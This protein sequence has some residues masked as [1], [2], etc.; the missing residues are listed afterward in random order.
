MVLVDIT[1]R[2]AD[3]SSLPID[4]AIGTYGSDASKTFRRVCRPWVEEK[5]SGEQLEQDARQA[6]HVCTCVVPHTSDHLPDEDGLFLLRYIPCNSK[7]CCSVL[8]SITKFHHE[9]VK[10]VRVRAAYMKHVDKE[11]GPTPGQGKICQHVES[12]DLPF[13]ILPKSKYRRSSITSGERYCRVWMSS[14]KCLCVQQA[15]PRSTMSTR[16][17]ASSS[18][19]LTNSPARWNTYKS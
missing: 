3:Y 18:V 4:L 7:R 16:T 5:V 17:D 12:T 6:P 2:R 8:A 10:L 19:K 15:F 9:Y 13:Y 14:L 11:H 1:S